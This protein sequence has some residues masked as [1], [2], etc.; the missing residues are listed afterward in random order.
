MLISDATYLYHLIMPLDCASNTGIIVPMD[1]SPTDRQYTAD[2]LAGLSN[3]PRRTI[4]YYIQLGLVGRPVGET[5]AAY[6]TWQH[7]RQ[8]LEIRRLTEEGYSLERIAEKLKEG[9]PHAAR[10]PAAST[11]GTVTVRSHIYL[12]P[13][14]ELSIDPGEAR[15]SPEQLRALAR[16]VITAYARTIKEQQKS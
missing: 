14:L 11:P 16:A 8:L 12:A 7:L 1:A 9:D 10:V 13:G 2:D 6:Y 3:T 4:R 15:L 5:R